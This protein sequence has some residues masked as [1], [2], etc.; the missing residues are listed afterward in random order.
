[1]PKAWEI[2]WARPH[3]AEPGI[4]ALHLQV[5]GQDEELA[6]SAQRS[7]TATAR[8]AAPHGRIP[9]HC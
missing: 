9:S 6:H 4:A 1:M 5:D 7:M 8:T 2:C 3:T